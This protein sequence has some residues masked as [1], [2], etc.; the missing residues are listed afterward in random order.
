MK[1]INKILVASG[2]FL[3]TGIF[4]S[5]SYLDMD[6]YFNDFT[7]LDSIFARQEYLER[8]LWGTAGL[9][10]NEGAL[11]GSSYGPY[12][13]AVDEVMM[14]W[15][16]AEYGGTFLTADEVTPFSTYYNNYERYY[17]GIRK[18]NTI[19]GRIDEAKDLEALEKR[20]I[21]GLT[22]FLRGY[23]YYQLIQLYGPVPVLPDDPLEVDA[24]IDNLSFERS[25]YDECVDYICKDMEQAFNFL[26]EKRAAA[27]FNRPTK[28]AAAAV[29]SRVR[30][31]QASPWF[32]GNKFYADW[33]GSDGKH[34]ISQNYDEKKWALSA[35]ASLKIIESGQFNLH[36]VAADENTAIPKNTTASLAAFPNGIGGI[37]PYKSY[38]EMFNGE[39][40]DVRNPE[41][42]YPAT[43]DR[44][45]LSIAFPLHMGGWNGLGVTQALVDGYYTNVGKDYQSTA[46]YFEPIGADS[47]F[48][49]YTL[50]G[51][52]AR[53]FKNREP[54]F[55]ASIGFSEA[56][57]P[58][59]SLTNPSQNPEA[60]TYQTIT[61]YSNGNTAP[62]SSNPEDYNLTG[63]SMKKYIHPEDNLWSG[64]AV[65]TKTFPTFRY[66]EILL[67]YVE[68]INELNGSY[69]DESASTGIVYT[70]NRNPEHIV[71]YFNMI[72]FRAGLPGITVT[73]AQDKERIRELIKRE[74]LVE[75]AHEGRRYHDVRR[76][77]IA[78]LT[79]NEPV[80]GMDVTKKNTERNLFYRVTNIQH[81]Y[82][83]RTFTHKMYFWPIPNSAITKNNKLTQ[84]PGW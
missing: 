15:K 66:A 32:N 67:N 4:S 26:E 14:S 57:W 31:Y 11:Y 77:G 74:R 23:F 10:P 40:I 1:L 70:V 68:A 47:V 46:D 7:P 33:V 73:D 65:K 42:I 56:F 63:Y 53:M 6:S 27:F 80:R 2:M 72:R 12:M 51:T 55:Y 44:N 71:K 5:C 29:I 16:K 78:H 22:Y 13:T 69:S 81:K 82:A 39:T 76:W 83:F 8:Y 38:A 21:L 18:C 75:F 41:I 50:K 59:N 58:A 48:S 20:E 30:L 43:L 3:S 9:L 61:Y 28:Y 45:A 79:E 36:T 49:N 35:L 84:N 64:G 19:L 34:L 52:A 24:S 25:T 60:R 37:D 54:R 62:Q 17:Q